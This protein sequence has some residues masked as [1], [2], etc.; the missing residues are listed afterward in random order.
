LTPGIWGSLS[1]VSWGTADFIAR[2]T[3]RAFGYVNALLGMLFVSCVFITLWFL[4]SG[5]QAVWTVASLLLLVLAGVCLLVGTLLLY[6]SLIRGPVTVAAPIAGTYPA[7]VVLI[8]VILGSRPS[9]LQ[10]VGT[11]V[12]FAGVV[13]VARGEAR[14]DKTSPGADPHPARETNRARE[15]GR[16]AG[17]RPALRRTVLI[18]IGASVMFA[19]MISATQEAVLVVGSLQTLWL[20][21]LIALGLLIV[22][23]VVATLRGRP[24]PRFPVKWW[25]VFVVH[26]GLDSG[27]YY[28]LYLAATAAHPEI[29]AMASSAYYVVTVILGRVF[30]KERVTPV[31]IAGIVLVFAGVLTLSA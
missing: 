8:A 26:A 21:R 14:P 10:W 13:V 23:V 27:G 20:P 1:A 4:L 18:A 7:I 16:P 17:R 12:T 28:G 5:T 11:V 3:G 15:A 30:L 31:Q 19:V 2:F 22:F 6:V 25:P 24:R 9:L 29:A